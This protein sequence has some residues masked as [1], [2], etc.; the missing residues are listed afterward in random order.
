MMALN[1][2]AI[3]RGI[4]FFISFIFVTMIF[5]YKH[6]SV[7]L[8]VITRISVFFIIYMM[9]YALATFAN[10]FLKND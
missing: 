6:V 7:F 8:T 5:P 9:L 1:E 10:Q 2:E 4:I 3:K